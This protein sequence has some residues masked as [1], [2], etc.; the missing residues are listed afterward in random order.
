MKRFSTSRQVA[1]A[2]QDMF[3]LVADVERYP[4]FVPLCDDLRIKKRHPVEIPASEDGAAR[5]GELLVADMTVAYKVLR[6]TFTSQVRLDHQ[7]NRIDVRYVD[8]PFKSLNNVWRFDACETGGSIVDFTIA[9][10]FRSRTF[11]AIAGA[12]F[13]RAFQRFAEAFEERANQVYG[14][15]RV[16]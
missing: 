14:R 7:A 1:H 13:D 16:A 3:A 2:A 15:D 4:E 11:Q 10:S 8:G 5:Q 9:Y 6:E 12:V